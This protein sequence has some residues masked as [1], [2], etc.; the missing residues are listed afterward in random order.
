[1]RHVCRVLAAIIGA[2]FLIPSVAPAQIT[3]GTVTGRVV[4]P[5]GAV[6]V[7]AH[8]VL[9]SDSH[10]TRSAA[11]LTND[12]GDYV[13]P[14]VTAYTYTIEVTAPSFKTLRRAGILV[15][16]GDTKNA[17]VKLNE[18]MSL[19]AREDRKPPGGLPG[20]EESGGR[21]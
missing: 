7:G 5:T 4:D 8:V 10:G 18:T 20:P 3:T 1:M 2:W 12:S 17:G 11:A 14:D 16:G 21:R 9:I 15:T 13:F 19:P 6:L